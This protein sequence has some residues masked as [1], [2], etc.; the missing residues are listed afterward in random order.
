MD[1]TDEY[2]TA[3]TVVRAFYA[4]LHDG[5]GA[6]ASQ[7]IMPEKRSLPAF[8]PGAFSRFYGGLSKPIDLLDIA[9]A[10]PGGYI[11][12]YR[13]ATTN[14]QCDGKA[15]IMTV[16]RGERFYISS[17]HPLNGC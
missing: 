1:F 16:S 2:G 15:M 13:Y 17:I 9:S 5:Q 11:A 3:A 8:S 12:H 6:P 7:M 14:R 10:G 4:A